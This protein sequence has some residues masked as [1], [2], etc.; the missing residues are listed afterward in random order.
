MPG[1]QTS[2]RG[3]RRGSP[4]GLASPPALLEAAAA[5]AGRR[6]TGEGEE[7]SFGYRTSIGKFSASA[8]G[9]VLGM[10]GFGNSFRFIFGFNIRSICS[11]FGCTFGRSFSVSSDFGVLGT[12]LRRA[13][14][15]RALYFVS[16]IYDVQVCV[17]TQLRFR[18]LF[19][20]SVSFWLHSIPFRVMNG[21]S[22]Y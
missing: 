11:S 6:R 1:W 13:A 18:F 19:S 8:F 2:T 12:R 9:Y 14:R 17:D 10:F 20:F 15:L 16:S 4:S 22:W 3:G 21:N 7:T 5:V